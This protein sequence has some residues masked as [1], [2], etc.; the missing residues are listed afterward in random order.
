MASRRNPGIVFIGGARIE[1]G[2]AFYPTSPLPAAAML[3]AQGNFLQ[4]N[5]DE[6]LR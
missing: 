6:G 5:I 3:D 4:T 2:R 1:A